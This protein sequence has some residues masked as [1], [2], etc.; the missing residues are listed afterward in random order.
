MTAKRVK[1]EVEVDPEVPN[2]DGDEAELNGLIAQ[3]VEEGAALD[4]DEVEIDL[5]EATSY[6]PFTAKVAVEVRKA[7]L[8]RAKGGDHN[9]YIELQL[10][11]I[12]PGEHLKRALF[13]NVTLKGTGAGFGIE[14][15]ESLGATSKDG[16]L[17]SEKN[18]RVYPPGL[19]G[20]KGV[21]SCAPD[22]REEYNHKTVVKGALKPYV[23]PDA[24]ESAD[25][26]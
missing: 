6:K 20:L 7:T 22:E 23:S 10:S 25:L 8:K 9:Q 16:E 21:A 24:A 1:D 14:T 11:V 12:E 26:K 17:I 3:S 4:D 19:V 18:R 2:P 13:T 5:T 15:L